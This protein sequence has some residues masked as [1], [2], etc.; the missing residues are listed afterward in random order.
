[1]DRK[2]TFRNSVM[3]DILD[4][5]LASRKVGTKIRSWRVSE[6]VSMSDHG[7]IIFELTD[8]KSERW[9]WRNPRK[10]DWTVYEEELAVKVEHLLD[11]L[12]MVCEF[13]LSCGPG[14]T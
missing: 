7:H 2:P 13:E 9:L 10:K 12:R 8:L 1:M 14:R 6:E 3:E 11:K 4:I 5:S